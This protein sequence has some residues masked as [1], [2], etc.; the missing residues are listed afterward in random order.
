MSYRITYDSESPKKQ[1]N[2]L[3]FRLLLTVTFFLC[4]IWS[5]NQFWPEGRDLLKLLLIPGDPDTTL[6]AAEV[7]A[8]ELADGQTLAGAFRR[9]SAAVIRH[10]TS[11]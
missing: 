2:T 5:V 8:Q 9:F 4:F 11:G 7:F 1:E 10:G 6:E 3:L